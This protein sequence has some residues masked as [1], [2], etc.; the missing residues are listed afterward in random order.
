MHADVSRAYFHAKAQRAVLVKLPAEDWSGKDVGNFGLL[1]KRMYG[2]RDAES[3]RE[4]DRHLESW[5]YELG[6]QFKQPVPQLEE[7]NFRFDTR[8]RFCGD[9]NEGES[10]GARGAAGE[11][12][13]NQSKHH[14]GRF[15]TQHQS[16]ES[17]NML[18]RDRIFV[19]AR[20]S[21]R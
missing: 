8:R 16:V 21:A 10:G 13:P 11:R 19:S 6:A 12:V 1:K 4:K 9:R 17:E 20:P 18:G 2:S 3:N 5:G 15:D 7:E 14:R